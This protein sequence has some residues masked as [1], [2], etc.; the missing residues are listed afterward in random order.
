MAKSPLTIKQWK[1][2]ERRLLAGERARV[3][4]REFGVSAT[5]ILKRFGSQTKAVKLVANQLFE[6]ENALNNLP[7]S[8]QV[9]SRKLADE[10]LDI[11]IHLAGAAKYGSMT[12]HRLAGIANAQ[13]DKIDDANVEVS[14]EVIG[15]I[16]RLQ[17]VSNEAAKTGLNLLAANKAAIDD[18]NKDKE[19][20]EPKEII[21]TVIDASA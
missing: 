9:S 5:A 8:L 3:L 14:M 15:N 10:L 6:A 13:V 12:A 17:A 19:K 4:G 2:I 21:F 1:A 7:L 11:S 16:A 20:P 18:L